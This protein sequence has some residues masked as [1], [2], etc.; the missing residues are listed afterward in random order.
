MCAHVVVSDMLNLHLNQVQ[1]FNVSLPLQKLAC[2]ITSPVRVGIIA[3]L[4]W[5]TGLN[6]VAIKF[7][8]QCKTEAKHTYLLG[9]FTDLVCNYN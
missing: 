9:N 3:E 2:T 6:Q 1:N 5:T 4:D 8:V 7:L